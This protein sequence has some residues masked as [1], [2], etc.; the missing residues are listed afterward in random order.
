[1]SEMIPFEFDGHNIR[2]QVDEEGRPWWVAQDVCKVL[3]IKNVSNAVGRLKPG[4]KS[5]RQTDNLL[6]I[7]ESGLYRLI[8]RSDKPDA[9]RFQ[10]WVFR[11][12]LPSIR[13]TG[14]YSITPRAVDAYP[15]LKALMEVVEGLAEARQKAEA[16]EL[17]A[18]QAEAKADIAMRQQQWL[19]IREY[20]YLH[21]LQR[22]FPERLWIE[23]GRY[24][25]GYCLEQG[26]PVRTQGIADRRYGT[27]HAYHV[28]IMHNLL[29]SW[30]QRHQG[31][32]YLTLLPKPESE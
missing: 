25:T 26:I 6:I 32:A 23:F 10:D 29:P 16:A 7:N 22:Q 1:M 21:K 15:E 24:L 2:V 19:T 13:N 5:I 31:Q 9:D 4:E 3:D 18:V 11:E 8:F 28:E 12:V 14:G 30:L 20:V 27:E 17:H